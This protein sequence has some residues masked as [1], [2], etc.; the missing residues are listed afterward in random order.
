MDNLQ[1]FAKKHVLPDELIAEFAELGNEYVCSESET[2][3]KQWEIGIKVHEYWMTIKGHQSDETRED[4]WNLL[5]LS[6]RSKNPNKKSG[7]SLSSIKLWARTVR[8]FL[9]YPDLL[10]KQENFAF[11]YFVTVGVIAH[12]HGIGCDQLFAE[13]ELNNLSVD[14]LKARYKKDNPNLPPWVNMR[15]HWSDFYSAIADVPEKIR[16]QIEPHAREIER[17]LDKGE[18]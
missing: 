7:L 15:K 11:D 6:L 14:E 10:D 5:V 2:S 17:I 8:R 12:E 13:I 16:K 4:I 18:E 1:T 3:A 9:E